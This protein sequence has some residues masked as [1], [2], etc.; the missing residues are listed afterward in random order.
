[1]NTSIRTSKSQETGRGCRQN[2]NAFRTQA[3][4]ISGYSSLSYD[5]RHMRAK[6]IEGCRSVVPRERL[7]CRLG[8]GPDSVVAR[9]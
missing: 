3:I 6:L 9:G 4:R 5:S 2:P 1:M 8:R 7:H